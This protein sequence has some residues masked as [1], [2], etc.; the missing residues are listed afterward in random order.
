[1]S[2]KGRIQAGALGLFCF[3]PSAAAF[4]WAVKNHLEPRTLVVLALSTAM[5]SLLVAA[6]AR[7]WRTFFLVQFP[8]ILLGAG[9]IGYAFI[10]GSLPGETLAMVALG[11]S[12][13]EVEGS[14]L[15]WRNNWLGVLGAALGVCYLV[16]A[17]RCPPTPIFSS[18][19][20]MFARIVLIVSIPATVF[21]AFDAAETIDGL[22]VNPIIGSLL[23]LGTQV[24]VVRSDLN[25]SRIVKVPYRATRT[26]GEEVHVLVIGESSRRDSWSVYGYGR[27]TT[28]Y[29][30]RLR[31]EAVFLRN[32][33]ADANVTIWSV[34]M[35]LTGMRPG[36]IDFSQVH[37]NLLDLAREAHYRTSWLV[38]Q[39]MVI[40][41]SVGVTPDHLQVPSGRPGDALDEQLLPALRREIARSGE[42]RFIGLHIMGSHWEYDRRYPPQ[43]QRF[44]TAHGLNA[45]SLGSPAQSRD[46]RDAYDNSVLYTDWLLEQV[47][48][49]VRTVKVPATVTFMPDHGED[50]FMLDGHTGH[51]SPGYTAHAF[52]IPA[53]VW[54]NEAY[55]HAHPQILEALRE[56]A[57]KPV[58]GHDIFYAMADIM[59]ISWPGAHPTESF[60]ASAFEPDTTTPYIAGGN[61]VRPP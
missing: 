51:G 40:G 57:G 58:R 41:L 42:P 7:T 52:T 15:L 11:T 13:E 39:D 46:S 25:G 36:V 45:F 50:L 53:F 4:L 33:T 1:M 60:A 59:G 17:M 8:F 26:G 24:P 54:A 5:M 21:A 38:N 19:I 28:P 12:W 55:R 47:I 18:R 22:S 29:L 27:Q 35:M 23:F 6:A 61:L 56:N 44:G 14:F 2:W 49:A 9:F 3:L 16:L 48:E 37:G 20:T 32:A 43:F 10:F 34:P 31:D 30:D